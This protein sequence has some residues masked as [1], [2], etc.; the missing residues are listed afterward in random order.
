MRSMFRPSLWLAAASVA[1]ALFLASNARAQV[2]ISEVMADNLSS[3]VDEDGDYSDWFE[4]L[5]AGPAD[6]DIGGWYLT[7]D[8]LLLTKWEIPRR[9]FAVASSS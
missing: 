4:L 8:P 5:N 2:V 6:V 3:H 7:D 9:R 1:S